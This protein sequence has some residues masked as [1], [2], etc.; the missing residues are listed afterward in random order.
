[1]TMK[2]PFSWL[3][4]VGNQSVVE[5]GIRWVLVGADILGGGG[6]RRHFHPCTSHVHGICQGADAKPPVTTALGDAKS[7]TFILLMV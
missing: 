4:I 2:K 1:M 5:H 6:P 3:S 7:S